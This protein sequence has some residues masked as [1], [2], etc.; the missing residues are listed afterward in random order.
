[1]LPTAL[2]TL[3]INVLKILLVLVLSSLSVFLGLL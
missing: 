3:G 2:R 1:M